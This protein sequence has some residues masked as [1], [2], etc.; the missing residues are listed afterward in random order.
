LYTPIQKPEE[1]FEKD[2]DL[3]NND[4]V[5]KLIESYEDLGDEL[6]DLQQR[7]G[8][9]REKPLKELIS[10]IQTSI[11][12]ELKADQEAE[13]FKE[14]PRVDFKNAVI[15]LRSYIFQYLKDHSIYL[16]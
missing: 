4:A 12:M 5:R 8:F 7:S 11:A 16:D 14:T 13:R 9:S 1:F 6:I 15:N 2:K 3:L 10:Q